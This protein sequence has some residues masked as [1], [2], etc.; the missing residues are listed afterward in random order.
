MKNKT[1]KILKDIAEA[2]FITIQQQQ[3]AIEASQQP[4]QKGGLVTF[5][6]KNDE[7]YIGFIKDVKYK[8]KDKIKITINYD[9]KILKLSKNIRK[10]KLKN[11]QTSL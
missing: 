2:L 9:G 7:K 1:K 5:I 3:K 6:T 10:R 8:D 11:D 4:F